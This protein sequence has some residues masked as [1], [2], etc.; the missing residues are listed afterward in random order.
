MK[1]IKHKTARKKIAMLRRLLS[2]HAVRYYVQADPIISD[3]DYDQLFQELLHLERQHPEWV[4]DDSPTQ[5]VGA[6]VVNSPFTRVSHSNPMLS[7]S[8][9]FDA[10]SALAFDQ[11]I[12]QRLS[13]EKIAYVCEPK[14]DGVAISLRYEQGQLMRA[15][16]RGDGYVGEDVTANVRTIRSIPLRLS[17]DDQPALLEVRG[18]IYMTH[19]GFS[20]LNAQMAD[21]GGRLFANPRNAAAGSLRQLEPSVVSG[22]P[23]CFS[24]YGVGGVSEDWLE[25]APSKQ[26]VWLAQLAVWGIPVNQDYQVVD[27]ITGALAYYTRLLDKRSQLAYDI[28][29]VVYKIDALADQ[30]TLGSISRAPRWAVA[31]K[32]PAE[33]AISTMIGIDYQVG[34]TG[35]LTPVAR[36]APVRVGGVMVR[37]ATLH[38]V[39]ELRRKDIRVGDC[40]IVRRAGDVIPAVERV[41]LSKRPADSKVPVVPK[42]CPVC[43][44][45]VVRLTGEVALRCSGGI[46]CKAQL[47]QSI[48]HFCS[49][50]AF[51]I[52][53]LGGKLIDLLVDRKRIAQ[54]ADLYRLRSQ[55]VLDL[56]L[57]GARRVANLLAAIE[58]SKQT[59]FAR[60]LYSLGMRDVGEVTAGVLAQH[61]GSLSRLMQASQE[62]LL[63]LDGIGET[64]A[65]SIVDFFRQ[66]AH[67]ALLDDLQ[68]LGV[69]WPERDVKQAEDTTVGAL[70]GQTWVITGRLRSMTREEAGLRLRTLGAKIGSQ[71]SKRTAVV[72]VGEEPGRKQRVAT[73]LGIKQMDEEAFL[74][75]KAHNEER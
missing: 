66:S 29:G 31:H 11:R 20:R 69:V 67:R 30:T 58:Q 21:A 15:V 5:R 45:D 71:V 48:W 26:S 17:G 59:T 4:T 54:V 1:H 44:A 49:R 25:A 34:R 24:A 43:K 55:D 57:M 3:Q 46:S 6:P 70:S 32:F 9:V 51:N 8:N 73:Q 63:M 7:L 39:D 22:R 2:E 23:L 40:V 38:N 75:L 62:D 56:P 19:A 64:V 72:L 42:R 50:K 18:E 53:G 65:T 16:T 27:G 60:L 47:K 68:V 12:R 37:H 61:F 52:E 28:D 13:S 35:V 14:L 36:L 10:P 33:E 41:V 74:A